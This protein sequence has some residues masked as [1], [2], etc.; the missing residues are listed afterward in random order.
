M[1]NQVFF[2]I[3]LIL[4]FLFSFIISIYHLGIEQGIF[5]ESSVC[6]TKNFNLITKEEILITFGGLVISCKDVAF[7]IFGFSLTTYNIVISALML[8]LS[9]KI[10]LVINGVKK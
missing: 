7:K 5:K 4:I 10:Y 6:A 8:L 3:L 2:C 1:K 9:I